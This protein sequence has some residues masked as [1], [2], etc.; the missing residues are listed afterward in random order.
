MFFAKLILG[1]AVKPK[2]EP[3]RFSLY[4]QITFSKHGP[5]GPPDFRPAAILEG[6]VG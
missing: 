4:P 1:K 6:P 2:I 5:A 3:A